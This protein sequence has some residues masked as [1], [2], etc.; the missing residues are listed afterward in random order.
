MKE[1]WRLKAGEKELGSSRLRIMTKFQVVR[2]DS[3]IQW[4]ERGFGMK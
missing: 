4:F 1:S 3:R 2:R